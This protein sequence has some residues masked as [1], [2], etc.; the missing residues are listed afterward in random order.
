MQKVTWLREVLKWG[1]LKVGERGGKEGEKA[2][3]N[4]MNTKKLLALRRRVKQVAVITYSADLPSIFR[5]CD[6]MF[7][8]FSFFFA[9][10]LLS[11]EKEG[12]GLGVSLFFQTQI[13]GGSACED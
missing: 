2:T 11:S 13:L 8:F 10:I 4:F 6:Y 7:F 5:G 3:F 12:K 9:S 1:D